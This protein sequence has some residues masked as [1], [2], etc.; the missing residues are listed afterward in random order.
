MRS[1]CYLHQQTQVLLSHGD[2]MCLGLGGWGRYL[3][4]GVYT[5]RLRDTIRKHR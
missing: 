2:E 3:A 4:R 5:D 1:E